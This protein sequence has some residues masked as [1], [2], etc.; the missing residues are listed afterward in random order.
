MWRSLVNL[1]GQRFVEIGSFISYC[2]RVRIDTDQRELE[3][4]EKI[5][6]MFPVARV[7]YPDEY[8]INGSSDCGETDRWP[9][10]RRLSEGLGPFPH[11]YGD[12]TGEELVHCFDREM[13]AEDN[14]YLIRPESARFQPWSDYWVTVG[15][16]NGYEIKRPT[17]KH[18]YSYWQIYQLYH[19]QQ[20]PDLYRNARLIELVPKDDL[21]KMSRPWAPTKEELFT[22]RGLQSSFDALSF[23]IVLYE[24]ERNRTFAGVQERHGIRRLDDVQADT[25]KKKLA[26]HAGMVTD[27]FSIG[28]QGLYV[29]L[30]RLIG[31]YDEY[32]RDERQSLMMELAKDI[33][34]WEDLIVLRTGETRDAIADELGKLNPC[35]NKTFLH[36]GVSAKERDRALKLLNS[37]SVGCNKALAGLGGQ[38]WSFAPLEAEELIDYCYQEGLG[39]LPSALSGMVAIG[40][41][42]YRQNFRRVQRYTNL[43]NILTSYEYLL[44]SLGQGSGLATGGETLTPLVS[45]VMSNETWYN[46]FCA[47]K[48][49]GL[50]KGN[51]TRDFLANLAT[52]HGDSQLKGSADGYWAQQFLMTCL[53]RNMTVHAYPTEDS[54]YGDLFG[55]MLAA[56]VSAMF[57]TWRLA[58]TKG[59]LAP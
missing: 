12:L 51:N 44:K 54:Y 34:A 58:R 55:P 53:A 21:A 36:L 35:H 26:S 46:L 19:I 20:Y 14:P 28:C 37:V 31:V 48:R 52:L 9:A 7:V 32:E 10:L 1:W 24:Q 29:F 39:L 16:S 43:K 18:Y 27:R 5:G 22:F 13:N 4:Y 49:Q 33:L 47:K 45:K 17:A 25:Y 59:W 56:V 11:N 23:W 42:E 8:V 3:H 6:T 57:Y 38:V 2:R 50:L 30:S 41:D 15:E 40:E